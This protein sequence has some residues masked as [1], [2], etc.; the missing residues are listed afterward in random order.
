MLR[1]MNEADSGEKSGVFWKYRYHERL[2][3]RPVDPTDAPFQ[4]AQ[5]QTASPWT[6]KPRH[7]G[8]QYLETLGLLWD[9][10]WL[11]AHFFLH[12]FLTRPLGLMVSS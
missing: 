10:S 4:T 12:A 5:S 6:Q 8:P 7:Y 3:T 2:C 1:E 11:I 9:C